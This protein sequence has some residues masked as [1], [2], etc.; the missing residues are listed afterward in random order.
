MHRCAE[1]YI[2]YLVTD[3]C[4]YLQEG[5][6]QHELHA[7]QYL[8]LEPSK[9]HFGYR[10]SGCEYYYV[11]FQKECFLPFECAKIGDIRQVIM[12]NRHRA[13][14]CNPFE[15]GIYQEYK[16]FLPKYRKL[17]EKESLPRIVARMKEA[18]YIQLRKEAH[19]KL[20]CSCIFLDMLVTMSNDFVAN[21]L[22]DT[23]KANSYRKNVVHALEYLNLHY[24][25]KITGELLETRLS[26]NFD[27]L[28]RLFKQD[29]GMTIFD[30][31]KTIRIQHAKEYL[32]TS[33]MKIYEISEAVGFTDPYYFSRVFKQMV[34]VSPKDF[35]NRL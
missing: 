19:Y 24:N 9:E 17:L 33:P 4:M 30:Y 27:A 12:E 1:E 2:L 22:E 8:F 34:G 28:N 20:R 16:L 25:E 18:I 5:E 11:H 26:V 13:Y 6:K 31:L 10:K 3:G 21:I 14:Q 29:V 23:E 32:V 15:Q 35:L 7:G